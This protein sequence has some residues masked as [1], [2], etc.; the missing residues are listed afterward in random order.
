MIKTNIEDSV[1]KN[2]S[3]KNRNTMGL[4]CLA[5]KVFEV[6]S[7]QDL[8]DHWE[9]ICLSQPISILGGGSNV[10]LAPELDGLVLMMRNKGKQQISETVDHF[11][12]QAE[13]GENWHEFVQ[14][15]VDHHFFGL[16]NLALIPGTVGASP[17]QNIGAYGREMQDL[18]S[19]VR[20]FNRQTKRI[21]DIEQK[22]CGFAYR[23]SFFKSKWR[24][25]YIILAVRFAFPKKWTPQ[26][27]YPELRKAIE[28]KNQQVTPELVFDT[29]V[30]IRKRKL[31]DPLVLGNVGSFFKNPVVEK[32]FALNLKA[33]FP[34]LP[35][36]TLD[37]PTEVK[38]SA[39]WMIEKCGWKGT[40]HGGIGVSKQHS[41]VLV[42]LG[43]GT[44]R[45]IQEV[46]TKINESLN[47]LFKLRLNVEPIF[48]GLNKI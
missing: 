43:G 41:L 18:C 19:S 11:I 10:I 35:V 14:W 32:S 16:E 28:E 39:A 24:E 33:K 7:Q 17:V 38:L 4:E 47:A 31:P 8:V 3:L 23:E 30:E 42:N 22:D 5:R 44:A 1:K 27:S 2:I 48:L 29:V 34:D 12:V 45:E 36:Y 13:A 21:E 40:T 25:T 9:Q 20:V 37:S 15:C 6:E 46:T 26:L